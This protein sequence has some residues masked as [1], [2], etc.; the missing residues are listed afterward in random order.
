M[1]NIESKISQVLIDNEMSHKNFMKII[2]EERNYSKL[3]E[4][5]RMMKSQRNDT[6]KINLIEEGTKIGTD[7]VIKHN[8]II[9][10]TL[11]SQI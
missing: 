3:K 7:E 2:N 1:N 5:I 9:N 10:N 6:E 4:N 8:E 11:K